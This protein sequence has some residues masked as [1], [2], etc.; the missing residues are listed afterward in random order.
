MNR[1]YSNSRYQK[2]I[3]LLLSICICV[4]SA[5][6]QIRG[7]L[8]QILGHADTLLTRNEKVDMPHTADSNYVKFLEQRIKEAEQKEATLQTEITQLRLQGI[9]EDSIR[10]AQQYAQIDSLR[11]ITPGVPMTVDEGTL[12]YCY[13]A[14]GGVT[15]QMRAQ[16]AQQAIETI[17]KKLVIKTDSVKIEKTDIV[18]DIMYG[19]QVLFSITDRDALWEKTSRDSLAQQ[20]KQIVV[21]KLQEMK[22]EY[23]LIRILKRIAYF[24]LVVAGQWLLFLFTNWIFRKLRIRIDRLKDTRL[25]PVMLQNYELLDTGK[26]VRLLQIGASLLRYLFMLVQLLFSVPHCHDLSLFARI[27]FRCIP[28]DFRFCRSDCIFRFY[29][30]NR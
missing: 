24:I 12:F 2:Y 5:Q 28:R 18:S 26:Q 7:K 17:G 21:D 20:R 16:N 4:S 15:P 22:E 13:I 10:H 9:L 14:R 19:N 25:K 8:T 1:Q 27:E 3:F 6:A 30:G 11:Q 29:H 23:G